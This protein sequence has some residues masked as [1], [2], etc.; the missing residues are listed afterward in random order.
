MANIYPVRDKLPRSYTV[1]SEEAQANMRRSQEENFAIMRLKG[2]SSN[3]QIMHHQGLLDAKH[4][5][6]IRIATEAAIKKIKCKQRARKPAIKRG[7][8]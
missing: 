7:S 8:K 4:Y 3:A 6:V 5:D 1:H 2:I